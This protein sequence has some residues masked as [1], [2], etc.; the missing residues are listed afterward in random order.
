MRKVVYV[1]WTDAEC[2]EDRW[3]DLDDAK[4]DF[5]TPTSDCE[6]VGFLL[7]EDSFRIFVGLTHGGD[8]V[9]PYLMIPKGCVKV[10]KEVSYGRETGS[11]GST[12]GNGRPQVDRHAEQ[13]RQSEHKKSMKRSNGQSKHKKHSE[14]R[15]AI[16]A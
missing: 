15:K 4:T 16:C 9:G 10:I 8:C 5:D 2:S 13:K 11:A 12:T 14:H 7:H 1:L 6:T 3:T